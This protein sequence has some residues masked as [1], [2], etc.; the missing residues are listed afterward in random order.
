MATI[1]A[2][3]PHPA[4]PAGSSWLKLAVA[5]TA[6]WAAPDGL[7]AAGPEA[8]PNVLLI[9]ADDLRAEFG[10]A[11][12]VQAITPHLD[13]LAGRGVTF[14]RAYCQQAVCNP[15]RASMLTGMRPDSIRVWDLQARFRETAPHAITLPEHFMRHGYHTQGIG[16]VFHNESRIPPGRPPMSDPQSW[17]VPPTHSDGAHWQD[18]VFPDE[19]TVQRRKAEAMQR[20]DV[21]DDTYFDGQIATAAV[22]AIGE[23]AA[24]D[25]PFFLTVGFWKPHLPFNAPA[26]YWDLYQAEDFANAGP[27]QLPEGAPAFA[28]HSWRELRGYVGIPSSGPLP[29]ELARDLRHGYHACISYLDAQ[30]GRL[31]EALEAS[32]AAANTLVVFVSDHGFHLGE[33]DLWAKTSNYELDARVPLIVADPR[34][35]PQGSH[36]DAIVELID[37][38]P[39]LAELAGLPVAPPWEGHSLRPV[40]AD[41]T[42]PAREAAVTQYPYPPYSRDWNVMGYA[43]RSHHFRFVSWLDRH[44]G[45]PVAR[46]LYDHRIDPAETVNRAADPAYAADLQ[47]LEELAR[48]SYRYDPAVHR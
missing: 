45:E 14:N 43:V 15:S 1:V 44:T 23:L 33:H 21:P 10:Y 3:T 16:K 8:R 12:N 35:T 27:A 13:R 38:A 30:V 41:P 19:P 31:L 18:W 40:L 9:I 6:L 24:A 46:E 39:T 29:D 36:T 5:S 7:Q 28:A 34:L 37:L 32:G 17:S 26:R 11:G 47:A 22:A 48:R 2:D 25:Q 42:Q 4:A 20:L